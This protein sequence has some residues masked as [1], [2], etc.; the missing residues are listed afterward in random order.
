MELQ[1]PGSVGSP[2]SENTA[3]TQQGSPGTWET[4]PSPQSGTSERVLSEATRDGWQGVGVPHSTVEAG[5]RTAPDPL[6]GR[7]HPVMDPLEGN[8]ADTSRSETTSTK[9]QRIAELSRKAPEMVWTTLSHNIDVDF[10]REAYARVRKGGAAGVDGMTAVQYEEQLL[11]NLQALES[12]AKSGSYVA[13]PVRR[14]EI[15]KGDGKQTR[16]IGIPT[17]EDKILQRAV[18]MVL[19]AVYEQDFSECSYGFRPGRS[20]HQALESLWQGT[21]KMWGGWVVEV[22]IRE[23]F[24]SLDRKHLR[25]ILAKRVRDG[26]LTRLVGKWLKAGVMEGGTVSYPTSGTPQG[27]VISPLL[28]NIYL[29]EVLDTWWEEMIV[30]RLRGQAK[31]IRFAD[32]FVIVFEREHD[33]RRM[34]AVLPKRFGKYGLKI[35][36]EKTRMVYFA[37]S[38]RRQ[39][40]GEEAPVGGAGTFD[41]LGL[42]HYWGKSRYGKMVVRRKT[43]RRR[44]SR[45]LRNA[46]KWLRS[47][48]HRP[49]PWQHRA[50]RRKLLGHYGYYGITG[51]GSALAQVF[52]VVRRLWRKWLNRRSHKGQMTWDDYQKLLQR[53][54]LPTPR[55]VHSMVNGAKP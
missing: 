17:L 20:A 14:V 52:D 39:L 47:V 37:P 4:L 16:P 21:M 46:N 5:E 53:H 40:P 6:E 9:L 31:L 45:T 26:V 36:P 13:P 25:A 32:D 54:P 30:P 43:A 49:I 1:R 11:G 44:L 2:G 19:E 50:L 55:V 38:G 34:M 27:G 22:D 23:F 35:H 24:D 12:R 18:A 41:F 28:A 42:T 8:V 15:P 10:L 51:N 29:H 3:C 48:R 33:A 7:G